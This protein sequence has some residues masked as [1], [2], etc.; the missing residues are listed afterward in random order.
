MRRSEEDKLHVRQAI[1]IGSL[2]SEINR[3]IAARGGAEGVLFQMGKPQFAKSPSVVYVIELYE[4]LDEQPIRVVQLVTYSKVIDELT[5]TL[6][7]L[8]EHA[9]G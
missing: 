1:K 7:V 9:R 2:V 8:H 3:Q 6:E 4:N 5:K